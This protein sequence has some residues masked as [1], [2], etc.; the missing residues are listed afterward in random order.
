MIRENVMAGNKCIETSQHDP[1]KNLA[2]G[3]KKA[4]WAIVL[5]VQVIPAR[6]NSRWILKKS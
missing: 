5:R 2:D 6:P 4:D 3:A 1:L